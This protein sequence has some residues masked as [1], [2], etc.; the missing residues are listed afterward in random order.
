MSPQSSLKAQ[1]KEEEAK[2]E[3][4]GRA[5]WG[6]EG[7]QSGVPFPKG[8]KHSGLRWMKQNERI[9]SF[10]FRLGSTSLIPKRVILIT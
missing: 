9:D 4:N 3:G 10:W 6:K 7:E 8:N 1:K 2:E 5:N